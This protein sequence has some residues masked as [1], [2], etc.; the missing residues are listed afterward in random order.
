V[1]GGEDRRGTTTRRHAPGTAAAADAGRR[2]LVGRHRRQ[3]ADRRRGARPG[4]RVCRD[5]AAR[6]HHE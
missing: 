6:G 1:G 4:T 2:Q 5:I 3:P